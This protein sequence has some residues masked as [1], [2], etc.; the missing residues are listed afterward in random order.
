MSERNPEQRNI[1]PMTVDSAH[2]ATVAEMNPVGIDTL[3]HDLTQPLSAIANYLNVALHLL[4]MHLTDGP[5]DELKMRNAITLALAE[6]YRAGAIARQIRS[7]SVEPS[8]QEHLEDAVGC[9]T[10]PD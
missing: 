1:P 3:V 9:D 5:A 4:D 10:L 2:L 7:G 6:V 8:M